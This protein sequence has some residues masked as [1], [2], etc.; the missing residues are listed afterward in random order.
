MSKNKPVKIKRALI[1]VSN[2]EGIVNFAKK[3]HKLNIEIIF[4]ISLGTSCFS[5][6]H[7]AV[8]IYLSLWILPIL[9]GTKSKCVVPILFNCDI[10]SLADNSVS[11][12]TYTFVPKNLLYLFY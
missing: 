12:T 6:K 4:S 5:P 2:K 11:F 10:A 9:K 3:L 7:I 1:S 8:F